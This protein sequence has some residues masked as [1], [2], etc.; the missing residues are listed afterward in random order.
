MSEFNH[1]SENDGGASLLPL[2]SQNLHLSSSSMPLFDQSQLAP[3]GMNPMNA[4]FSNVFFYENFDME[5]PSIQSSF[6]AITP[7]SSST[8]ENDHIMVPSNGEEDNYN[9]APKLCS[10]RNNGLLQDVAG[11]SRVLLR[12]RLPSK[13]DKQ[14]KDDQSEFEGRIMHDNVISMMNVPDNTVN[15]DS[16]LG[17]SHN[18]KTHVDDSSSGFSSIDVGV[19][20]QA[21]VFEDLNMMDDDFFS[22]IDFQPTGPPQEL[23]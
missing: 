17:S 5:I 13:E 9:V 15:L 23:N 8:N 19:T 2:P 14:T 10:E 3:Y 4:T 12:S 6:Q 18:G 16:V 21:H 22:W 20:S 1:H 7:T 11:Q